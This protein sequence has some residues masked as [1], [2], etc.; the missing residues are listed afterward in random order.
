MEQQNVTL[1]EN[2]DLKSKLSEKVKDI[3]VDLIPNTDWD[4]LVQNEINNFFHTTKEVVFNKRHAPSNVWG[5][6]RIITST[7]TEMTPFQTIVWNYCLEHA[8]P[9]LEKKM[10]TEFVEQSLNEA[11]DHVNPSVKKE[12]RE[13]FVAKQFDQAISNFFLHMMTSHALSMKHQLTEE[14]RQRLQHG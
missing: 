6:E 9:L 10:T 7:S 12:A 5:A 2:V 4:Q 8:L 3:F 13:N 1:I 11:F 14:L